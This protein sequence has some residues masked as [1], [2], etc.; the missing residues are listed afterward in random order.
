MNKRAAENHC[1]VRRADL[2]VWI[3]LM[4][5]ARYSSSPITTRQ[6]RYKRN[7]IAYF[8]RVSYITYFL[9][10]INLLEQHLAAS[11]ELLHVKR[12]LSISRKRNS[13]GG[14][15]PS[16]VLLLKIP[17][18]KNGNVDNA[19]DKNYGEKKGACWQLNP[20]TLGCANESRIGAPHASV[21]SGPICSILCLPVPALIANKASFESILAGRF[22]KFLKFVK[23]DFIFQLVHYFGNYL[24][25]WDQK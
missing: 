15:Q 9:Y 23:S 13:R 21:L 2:R 14:L 6:N 5:K 12:L 19:I 17:S 3:L 10:F 25:I 20:R 18:D 11:S 24:Y 8:S 7:D 16:R 22:R 1:S 4:L